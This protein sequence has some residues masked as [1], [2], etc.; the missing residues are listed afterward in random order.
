MKRADFA[1]GVLMVI[2]IIVT[3]ALISF[4]PDKVPLHL[5]FF[6]EVDRIGSRYENLVL[7]ILS[8]VFGGLLFLIAKYQEEANR[9]MMTRLNIGFQLFMIATSVFWCTATLLSD[10]ADE[11]DISDWSII[12]F[13]VLISGT[14]FIFL[15]NMLPKLNMNSFAGIRTSWSMSSEEVW[16]KTQRFGGYAFIVAGSIVVVIGLLVGDMFGILA[17]LLILIVCS[18]VCIAASYVFYRKARDGA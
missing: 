8:L 7:P 16:R 4:M 12:K 1:V 5:D 13:L 3:A 14:L 10:G 6:G 2:Q 18:T 17:L 9:R 15:G 11:P